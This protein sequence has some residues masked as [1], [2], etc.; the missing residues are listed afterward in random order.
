M[1]LARLIFFAEPRELTEE[2]I[3]EA[4]SLGHLIE[5]EPPAPPEPLAPAAALAP[6]PA[7][8]LAAPAPAVTAAAEAGGTAVTETSDDSTDET[9]ET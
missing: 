1:P 9:Q 7:P 2:Q 3:T 8:A 4:R 5:D 6:A